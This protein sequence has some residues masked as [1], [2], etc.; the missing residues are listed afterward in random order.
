MEIVDERTFLRRPAGRMVLGGRWVYGATEG[1]PLRFSILFGAT[2]DDD[3]AA[4]LRLWRSELDSAG[5]ASLFDAAALTSVTP[6]AFAA[7]G[8][9][10]DEHK[11]RLGETVSRQALVRP[12]GMIGALVA[13]Y[14]RVS[15]PPYPYEVFQARAPALDWLGM[16]ANAL[17]AADEHVRGD[18]L[19]RELREYLG[20]DPRVSSL[21]HVARALGVSPRSLQRRLGAIGTSF[22]RELRRARVERA[23]QLL[24]ATDEKL[25][26]IA[27]RV[28]C[29][30]PASFSEMFAREVGMPPSAWRAAQETS[31]PRARS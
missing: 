5:H 3:L 14:Y 27:V 22:V 6:T 29:A 31:T 28:G 20:R 1:A 18:P 11:K 12:S 7:V 19:L 24:A 2:E 17:D 16:P 4:L 10:L 13:G 21:M 30:S 9:F 8:A 15:P 26:T 23:M 25:A